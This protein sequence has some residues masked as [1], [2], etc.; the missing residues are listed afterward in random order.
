MCVYT[1][2]QLLEQATR[3][4]TFPWNWSHQTQI[5]WK[6]SECSQSLS[7]LDSSVGSSWTTTRFLS[8]SCLSSGS[9]NFSTCHSSG[10]L[11]VFSIS[12]LNLS[13]ST[14]IIHWTLTV[15]GEVHVPEG[16]WG[17]QILDNHIMCQV[18]VKNRVVR[19]VQRRTAWR[20]MHH[21]EYVFEGICEEPTQ[22]SEKT[23]RINRKNGEPTARPW[24]LAFS[25]SS[26]FFRVVSLQADHDCWDFNH[27]M[28]T[29]LWTMCDFRCAYM[30]L[31]RLW[32][33]DQDLYTP[34]CP[35]SCISRPHWIR[36]HLPL[37][38]NALQMQIKHFHTSSLVIPG[39]ELPRALESK[40]G[41]A[42]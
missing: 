29:M 9:C 3:E 23:V 35:N 24:I 2:A 12:S 42:D 39:S 16:K 1:C 30:D 13:S 14:A 7:H 37:Y 31:L 11:T 15:W 21:L 6:S 28:R 25:C 26:G 36:L 40:G 27:V 34:T 5:L 17:R 41:K 33:F 4:L 19:K 20:W 10:F 8:F 38:L 22:L 32:L 18:G